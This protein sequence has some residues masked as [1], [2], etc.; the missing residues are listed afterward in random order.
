MAHELFTGELAALQ[1]RQLVFPFTGEFRRSQFA[2][3]EAA[4]QCNQGKSLGGGQQIAPLAVQIDLR[5]QVLDDLCPRRRRAEAA[6]GHR[7]AQFLVVQ[8][9]AGAFHRGEQ[10]GFVKTRGRTGKG[11][12]DVHRSGLQGLTGDE[13]HQGRTA[14][15]VLDLSFFAVHRQPAG[16]HQYLAFGLEGF[17]LL[18]GT[19]DAGDAGGDRVFRRRIEHR[20]EAAGDQIVELLFDLVE[21]L[22][23]RAGGDNGE[24]IGNLGV[25]E[26]A[27]V[28]RD[29]V[30][31]QN[32]GGQRRIGL[33]QASQ[34]L[35]HRGQVIF[36][37]RARVG[38]WI[39]QH[40]VPFVQ[41]LRQAQ[42]DLGG[43]A[44]P[45]VGF[46]L[47]AGEVVQER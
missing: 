43:E 31:F 35:F 3:A 19:S 30:F 42:S 41:R 29:P 33:G 20:Q 18:R 34:H 45:A 36:W 44:E 13:G 40:L 28:R 38:T 39:S 15:V 6:P 47:Q 5:D 23:R 26:D 12:L 8:Q 32:S 17:L 7:R 22:G 46:A 25:V 9:L 1:L 16:V 21:R 10:G 27:L 14:R 4:Q 11:G 2:D 37:Q 24:V